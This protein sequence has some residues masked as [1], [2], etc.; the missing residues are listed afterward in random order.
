MS[1]ITPTRREKVEAREDAILKA[2]REVFIEF[3]LE[4]ARVAEI[5]RRAGIAEG[6]VYLYYKTKSDLMRALLS[7]FWSTLVEDAKSVVAQHDDPLVQLRALADF[8]LTRVIEEI[9]FLDLSGKLQDMSGD[10]VLRREYMRPYVA[11]FDEIFQRCLDKGLFEADIP[12]WIPRDLFYGTLEY[13]ARTII[14]RKA[15]RPSGVVDNLMNVFQAN[16]GRPRAPS[17]AN[18][19]Q[20]TDRLEIAVQQ[21]ES[22]ILNRK[23]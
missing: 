2:A 15:K 21:L 10:G 16:Y 11:V 13:S 18:Q 23:R 17:E 20:L 12:R 7:D 1:T 6:T 8:H 22:M 3:G 14:L 4:G 5:G 9:S 19:D